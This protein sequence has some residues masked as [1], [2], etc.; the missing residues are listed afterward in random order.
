MNRAALRVA[1]VGAGI[2]GLA[3]AFALRREGIEATV[4]EQAGELRE[5][6]VG[7]HLAPNGS[8]IVHR[9]GLGAAL[10]RVAVR[11]AALEVRDWTS[12]RTLFR[13]PMGAVWEQEFGAPHYTVHRADLHRL[14]ADRLPQGAVRLGRRLVSH[15]DDGERVRLT[16]AD[17]TTAQ[18]DVLVGADGVHSIV[19]RALLGTQVPAFSGSS[20]FRGLV[21]FDRVPGL[22]RDT[23]YI[24]VG[25]RSRLL[26]YPV[27]RATLTFV[28]VVPDPGWRLES[29]S[30]PGDPDDLAA[31][32]AGGNPDIAAIA[33][34]APTFAGLRRWALYDREPAPTWGDGRV[35]LLGDAA[36]PMLPHHGQGVSQALEDAVALAHHLAAAPG[37]PAEALRRYAQLRRPHTADVQ[38]GSRGGGSLRLRPDGSTSDGGALPSLVEDVSWIHRYDVAAELLAATA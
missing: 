12:G 21:S 24:W 30:A 29:W 37:E 4:Y 9:W 11:P 3:A 27:G 18:A 33:S 19:R 35:T 1:V 7:M 17:G 5:V 28:C 22:P 38:L 20:A 6:G 16:F 26:A 32:T 23:M 8:R 13:Q 34:H 36:H 31:A 2:G 14:L 15:A 25:A 10:D